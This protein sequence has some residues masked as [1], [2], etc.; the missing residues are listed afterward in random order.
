MQAAISIRDLEKFYGDNQVLKGV[1]FDVFPG[2]IVGYI[3]PNG[4][5]KSTTLKIILGLVNGQSGQIIIDGQAVRFD[6]VDYKAKI[7][8]VPEAAVLYDSLTV[9]EHLQFVGRLYGLSET[10]INT[11]GAAM[12]KVFSIDENLDQPIST[13][14]KGMR[15]KLLIVASL[16]HNPS[17]VIFDEPINGMDAN[18]VMIFKAILVALTKSGKA[19]LYSSHIMDVVEK[20]SSRIILIKDGQIVADGQLDQLKQGDDKESLEDLF[21]KLTGFDN[22]NQLADQF[23]AAFQAGDPDDA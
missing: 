14:S 12:T 19:V 20:I 4:A 5:G 3:G 9:R 17:I 6:D 21:N 18:S 10:L 13:L 23:V 22:Y 15:Q 1:S 7:G 11:R 8:Y 2:E 16:I